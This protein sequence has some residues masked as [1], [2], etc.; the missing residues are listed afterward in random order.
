MEEGSPAGRSR[1]GGVSW[2][3]WG[4]GRS[5]GVGQPWGVRSGLGP[6]TGEEQDR[7]GPGTAW[8]LNG[9]D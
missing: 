7:P 5:F 2:G 6:R 4:L 9:N 8:S 3:L 1:G